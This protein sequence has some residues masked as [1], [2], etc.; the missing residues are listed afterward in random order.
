MAYF[1]RDGRSV[2]IDW[3]VE[4]RDPLS[5]LNQMDKLSGALL[6]QVRAGQV[7]F[8]LL[9]GS[10]KG[11]EFNRR[12]QRRLWRRRIPLKQIFPASAAE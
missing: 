11:W 7:V 4:S 9:D 6:E 12:S 10:G 1:G 2:L 8:R 5:E 3:S